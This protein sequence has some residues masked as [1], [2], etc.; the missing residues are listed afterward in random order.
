MKLGSFLN[1]Y[2][3]YWEVFCFV[4]NNFLPICIHEEVL[5]DLSKNSHQLYCYRMK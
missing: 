5:R 4:F 2:F 3:R 1:F